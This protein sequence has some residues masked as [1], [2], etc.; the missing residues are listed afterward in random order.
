MDK[1]WI[2]LTDRRSNEYQVGLEKFLDFLFDNNMGDTRIYC[3]CKKCYNRYFVARDETI[4][5]IIIDEF[6]SNYKNWTHHG[7]AYHSVNSNQ[8]TAIVVGD[9]DFL[10][11][12][13]P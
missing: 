9:D 5:H 1:S 7:E 6:M 2:S 8:S 3:P 4:A 10:S 12:I 11:K 13:V